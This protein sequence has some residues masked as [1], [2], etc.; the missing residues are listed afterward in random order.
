[1][2]YRG[3]NQIQPLPPCPR[4]G[5]YSGERRQK[6]EE[7]RYIV[8]CASCGWHTKFYNSKAAATREWKHGVL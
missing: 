8:R 5:Q 1:M 7:D 6:A 4:C 2:T 3:K